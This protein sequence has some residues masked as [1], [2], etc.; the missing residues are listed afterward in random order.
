M[1]GVPGRA[2]LEPVARLI[3]EPRGRGREA[4]LWYKL[5]TRFSLSLF[6][7]IVLIQRHNECLSIYLTTSERSTLFLMGNFYILRVRIFIFLF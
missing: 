2:D 1:S 7:E 4:S 3:N 6:C 5:R